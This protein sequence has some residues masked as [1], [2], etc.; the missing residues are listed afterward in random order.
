MAG[1]VWDTQVKEICLSTDAFIYRKM[2]LAA[3]NKNQPLLYKLRFKHVQI[4][5][6]SCLKNGYIVMIKNYENPDRGQAENSRMQKE[7]TG[8]GSQSGGTT[9]TLLANISRLQNTKNAR[10]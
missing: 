4:T 7:E 3:Q 1:A 5:T 2:A 10:I 8:G 6:F 9:K